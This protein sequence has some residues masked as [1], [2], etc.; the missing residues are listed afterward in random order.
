MDR[1]EILD[2]IKGFCQK[3][4]DLKPEETE[5]ITE[6]TLLHGNLTFDELDLVEMLMALER[7]FEINVEEDKFPLFTLKDWKVGEVV[8]EV[9]RQKSI[10]K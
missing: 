1:K 9:I 10:E 3:L 6:E 2:F 8:D 5:K 4:L 7:N